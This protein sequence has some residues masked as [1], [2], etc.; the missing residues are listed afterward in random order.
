M[1]LGGQVETPQSISPQRVRTALQ[2][3]R[4]RLKDFHDLVKN[5]NEQLFQIDL[6]GNPCLQGR[7]DRIS[8]SFFGS[9]ILYVSR[10]GKEIS[11]FMQ[12]QGHDPIRGIEGFFHSIPVVDIN[13]HI[14][15][16]GMHFQ[17]FQNRQDNIIDV[18][19]PGRLTLFG[20]MKPPTPVDTNIRLILIELDSPVQTGPGIE[21]CE[22]KESI[23]D[24]TIRRVAR[25]ELLQYARELT[26]IIGSD[27]GQELDIFV[28]VKS[29]HFSGS[30][31]GTMIAIHFG[32][33]FVGQDKMVRQLESMGFHGMR[34]PI[35]IEW[36]GGV[37]KVRD[38]RL[39]HGA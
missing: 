23:K 25:V 10:S 8:H 32:I 26:Q 6:I 4:P 28:R 19:K 33:E 35:I 27:F 22:F 18:T 30:G 37:I 38:A 2:D 21:L 11:I 24:G 9:N 36:A 12:T 7:I 17:Q 20:M 15:Y 39:S 31:G 34:G 16:S 14:Q 3:H 13:V 5:G 1:S 29:S